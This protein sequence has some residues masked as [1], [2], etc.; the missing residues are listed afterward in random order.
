MW[1]L[2]IWTQVPR[3]VYQA[4][5]MHGATSLAPILFFESGS[6]TGL[7]LTQ[8]A[9]MPWGPW[10]IL[11]SPSSALGLQVFNTMPGFFTLVLGTEFNIFTLWGWR[12]G[13][14]VKRTYCFLVENSSAVP[15]T[16]CNSSSKRSSALFCPLRVGPDSI[17]KWEDVT[18]GF[19]LPHHFVP[20]NNSENN[21]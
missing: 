12:H 3:L 19:F 4:L 17:N 8:E 2:R 16:A 10:G 14:V 13:S 9:G 15:T 18:L 11:V 6:L 1:V 21:Y 20:H 5:L 7:D